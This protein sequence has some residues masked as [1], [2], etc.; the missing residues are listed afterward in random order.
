[1]FQVYEIDLKTFTIEEFLDETDSS[2][3]YA[4]YG[5]QRMSSFPLAVLQVSD[6][7]VYTRVE[8][9]EKPVNLVYV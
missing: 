2:L 1:M 5:T 7:G 8:L 9:F 4:V 6:P 3:A